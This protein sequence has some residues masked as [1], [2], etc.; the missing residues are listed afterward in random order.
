MHEQMILTSRLILRPLSEEDAGDLFEMLCNKDIYRFEPGEPISLDQAREITLA[1][2]HDPAFWAVV[3]RAEQKMVGRLY[4]KQIKPEHL[5]TWELG[6]II[7]PIYQNLGYA[8]ESA[9]ALIQYGFSHLDVHRV[10]AYCSPDNIPSWRVMEKIGMR[11]EGTLK[12]NIYFKRDALGNPSWQDS[13]AYG[14]LK[15]DIV[16]GSRKME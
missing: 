14:L 15:E 6:Y 1:C 4:F 9:L 10:V 5:M 2:S 12:Q 13:F 11:R 8:S 7:N 16:S 3:L